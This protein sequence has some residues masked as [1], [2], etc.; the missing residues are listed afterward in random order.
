MTYPER[1]SRHNLQHLRSLIINGPKQWPGANYVEKRS[2]DLADGDRVVVGAVGGGHKKSLNY[3]D[4]NAVARDLKVGDVVERHMRDGDVVLFNR[5][6]SLHKLSIMCHSVKVMQDRTF[7]LN[8]CVCAPYNADFDGDDEMN[9]HLP[10]DRGS[11]RRSSESLMSVPQNICT[12][13][14][15][16][17]LVAATQD[18][19][20]AAFLLTQPDVFFSGTS[21]ANSLCMPA[22]LRSTLVI[23]SSSNPETGH[24]LDRQAGLFAHHPTEQ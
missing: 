14:N 19:V 15:G 23:T 21:S 9:L 1:V 5:Q 2:A 13:R 7:K 22:M 3:G 4:R 10:P 18:F 17:P 20:T 16:E 11:A 12:P 6:P 24:A 8:E